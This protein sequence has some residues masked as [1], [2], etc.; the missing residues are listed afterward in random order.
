MDDL[1]K[2]SSFALLYDCIVYH[3]RTGNHYWVAFEELWRARRAFNWL[4]FIW[5]VMLLALILVFTRIWVAQ[6]ILIILTI[7]LLNLFTCFD[8]AHNWHFK[9]K[10]HDIKMNWPPKVFTSCTFLFT[11]LLVWLK[12]VKLS[13]VILYHSNSQITIQSCLNIYRFLLVYNLI[14]YNRQLENIIIYN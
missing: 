9:V 2:A 11:F 13:H 12:L 6:S 7:D 1:V 8:P 14:F 3:W 5:L 4:R 10:D